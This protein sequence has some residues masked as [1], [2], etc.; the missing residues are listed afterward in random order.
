MYFLSTS[1]LTVVVCVAGAGAVVVGTFPIVVGVVG[2]VGFED[3][4][5]PVPINTKIK[6]ILATI[7]INFLLFNSFLL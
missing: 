2:A 4:L 1:T 5:H 7:A 6:K 3:G